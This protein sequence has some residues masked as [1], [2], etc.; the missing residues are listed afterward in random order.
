MLA[1]S[2]EVPDTLK[3]ALVKKAAALGFDTDKLIFVDH[4]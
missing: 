1:R 2:P 3:E 4:R